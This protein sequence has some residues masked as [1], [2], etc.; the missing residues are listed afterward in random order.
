VGE[1]EAT[2]R[3][4]KIYVFG[5]AGIMKGFHHFLTQ[6]LHFLNHLFLQIFQIGNIVA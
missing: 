3:I 1:K 4:L 2:I 6:T 5:C